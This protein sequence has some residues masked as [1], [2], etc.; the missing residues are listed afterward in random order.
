MAD[1]CSGLS[2]LCTVFKIRAYKSLMFL[3]SDAERFG[4]FPLLNGRCPCWRKIAE[5]FGYRE[6]FPIINY[7]MNN[8]GSI[9]TQLFLNIGNFR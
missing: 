8:F 9:C 6:F 3:K 2:L 7:C 4:K 1:K 5:M